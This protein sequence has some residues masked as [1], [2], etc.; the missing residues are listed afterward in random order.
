MALTIAQTFTTSA[1]TLTG[2][3]TRIA[4]PQTIQVSE[5][6]ITSTAPFTVAP[7]ATATAFTWPANT[8]FRL[9]VNIDGMENQSGVGLYC[10]GSAVAT[11]LWMGQATSTVT[12]KFV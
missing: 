1:A 3:P 12:N 5:V 2:T 9:P 7:T 8:P 4:P 6:W 10:T 11:F